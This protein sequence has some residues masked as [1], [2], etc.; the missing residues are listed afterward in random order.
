MSDKEILEAVKDA[1]EG[2]EVSDYAAGFYVVELALRAVR[3]AKPG[4]TCVE[5]ECSTCGARDCP[6]NEPLHYH[7]DGCPACSTEP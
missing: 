1:L 5:M 6:D 7:H 2:R 4:A 3:L